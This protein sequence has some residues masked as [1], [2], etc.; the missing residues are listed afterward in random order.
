MPGLHP[1]QCVS[2]A[3]ICKGVTEVLVKIEVNGTQHQCHPR[4]QLWGAGSP[5]RDEY[6][7]HCG[8]Q[9]GVSLVM[10]QLPDQNYKYYCQ[11]FADGSHNKCLITAYKF[12]NVHLWDMVSVVIKLNGN[13][14]K[15]LQV[16]MKYVVMEIF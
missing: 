2:Y 8:F 12:V 13:T 9:Q 1:Y 14:M 6:I 15:D 5:T 11:Y 3:L 10:E 4:F 7:V 16:P